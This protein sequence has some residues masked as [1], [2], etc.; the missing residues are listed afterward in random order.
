MKRDE[1]LESK[2][3]IKNYPY[4]TTDSD[5]KIMFEK[6]GKVDD[7]KCRT[8]VHVRE[9]WHVV[10]LLE[11]GCAVIRELVILENTFTLLTG[12][13][14]E[15]EIYVYVPFCSSSDA[16]CDPCTKP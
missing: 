13:C 11:F 10:L 6:Y 3:I 12:R 8:H 5:L 14:Y 15:A 2:V 1:R 9:W 16:L 4:D 7:C